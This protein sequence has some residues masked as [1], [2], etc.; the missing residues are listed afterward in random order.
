MKDVQTN[1][2]KWLELAKRQRYFVNQNFEKAKV[3]STHYSKV[4]E[5][6]AKDTE[7]IPQQ[8][9]MQLPKL[10]LPKLQKVGE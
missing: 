8:V 9:Q 2:K 3:Q 7:S 1:Y 6:V 5:T 10:Q 4:F